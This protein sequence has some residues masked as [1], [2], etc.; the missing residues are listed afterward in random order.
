[1][2]DEEV[3]AILA[4]FRDW[5]RNPEGDI[6]EPVGIVRLVD[7]FTALR[8][9]VKLLTKATRAQTEQVAAAQAPSAPAPHKDTRS[10]LL[11]TIEAVDTLE[12]AQNALARAVEP[13]PLGWW[14]R[15]FGPP[16]DERLPAAAEGLALA[17]Q[18]LLATLKRLGVD[19]VATTGQ[20]FNP[21]TM[22]AVEAVA[23]ATPGQVAEEVR[24]GYLRAGKPLRYAQV[25]VGK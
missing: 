6:P 15:W 22:E 5:L 21:E 10:L 9:E 18:R 8:H 2:S 14:A 3:E 12:R 17:N 7:E 11:A 23:G 4:E 25:R 24:A 19:R 16:A 20:A 13:R 1:M